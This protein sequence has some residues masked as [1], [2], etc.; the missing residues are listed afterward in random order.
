MCCSLTHPVRFHA[1]KS[2]GVGLILKLQEGRNYQAA[3]WL[4]AMV[5]VTW[6]GILEILSSTLRV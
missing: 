4:H 5:T 1:G 6:Q 3:L 2:G